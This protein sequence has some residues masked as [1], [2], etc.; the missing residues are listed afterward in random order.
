L[1]GAAFITQRPGEGRRA[2][3]WKFQTEISQRRATLIAHPGKV[4]NG[5]VLFIHPH[6]DPQTR[7][8]LVRMEIDNPEMTLRQGMYATVEILADAYREAPV[9]PR[10]AVIDTGRRQVVFVASGNGQ[11]VP[12][13]VTL[14][15][16]SHDGA[17]EIIAGLKE[18]APVRVAGVEVGSVSDL[19][20]VGDSVEVVM[21]V[22]KENRTRIT[23]TSIAS[24][25][26]VSLLG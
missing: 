13:E 1:H 24:L 5:K 12:R 21:E 2:L 17:I 10:E 22:N 15:L 19:S 23:S 16:P 3:R 4:F 20:F 11:Y 18:G 8:A 9:V 6:L 25:G 26:S 14:G 7:T